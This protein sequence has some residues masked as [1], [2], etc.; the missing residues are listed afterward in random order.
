MRRLWSAVV[1]T[2]LAVCL[3][4]CGVREQQKDTTEEKSKA[5]AVIQNAGMNSEKQKRAFLEENAGLVMTERCLY[6]DDAV[7]DL[8]IQ[9]DYEGN[10][11][12]RFPINEEENAEYLV[13]GS[14]KRLILSTYVDDDT[15]TLYNVPVLQTDD[16]ET[17]RWEQ[18]EKIAPCYGDTIGCAA[19]VVL[20]EP[21]LFYKEDSNKLVRLDMETGDRKNFTFPLTDIELYHFAYADEYLYLFNLKDDD[22]DMD[23]G[24]NSAVY[25]INIAEGTSEKLY[26]CEKPDED[27]YNLFVDGQFL[28]ILFDDENARDDRIECFDPEQKKTVGQLSV[29][30]IERLI[31]EEVMSGSV[32]E[33]WEFALDG[34]SIYAGRFYIMART[35]WLKEKGGNEVPIPKT[36]LLSCSAKD[37]TD[38]KYEQDLA[39]WFQKQACDKTVLG[40]GMDGDEDNYYFLYDSYESEKPNITH[41]M[42]YHLNTKQIEEV[43]EKEPIWKLLCG[44]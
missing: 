21:Y 31:K 38:L 22:V 20:C 25:R 17:V 30:E 41:L 43:D 26:E 44:E 35:S 16:G 28:Y 32:E 39:K 37:M 14:D 10:E 36:V 12:N 3:S 33:C 6:E 19:E 8:I 11:R 42:R 9:M 5:D 4:G 7:D 1:L 34:I 15:L 13:C 23:S 24:E 29:R 27:P 2:A 40:L 18:K